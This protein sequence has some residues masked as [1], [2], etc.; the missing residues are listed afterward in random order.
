MFIF[1]LANAAMLTL[2]RQAIIFRGTAGGPGGA[3]TT[4]IVLIG[5]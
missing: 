1:H 2:L 4:M 5:K 3:Y